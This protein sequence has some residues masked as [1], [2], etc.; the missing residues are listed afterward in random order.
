MAM[1][2]KNLGCIG[3]A[4]GRQPTTKARRAQASI[5][6]VVQREVKRKSTTGGNKKRQPVLLVGV[7][8]QAKHRQSQIRR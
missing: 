2:D 5:L 6:C 4:V 7:D 3:V 1:V 8:R